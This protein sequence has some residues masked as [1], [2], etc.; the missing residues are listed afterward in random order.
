MERSF[1]ELNILLNVILPKLLGAGS[2]CGLPMA[3]SAF[4]LVSV[5][6]TRSS[7]KLFHAK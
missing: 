7:G 3:N 1:N 2:E 5:P 4:I 6:L